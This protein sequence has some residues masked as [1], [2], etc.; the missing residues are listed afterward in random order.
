[1]QHN[2]ANRENCVVTEQPDA[3]TRHLFEAH[4]QCPVDASPPVIVTVTE[5]I[6]NVTELY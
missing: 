4:D 1:M 3:Q 5:M 6:S 2:A